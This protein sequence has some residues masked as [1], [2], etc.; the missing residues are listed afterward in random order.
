MR[1]P[2]LLAA[3]SPVLSGTWFGA[4]RTIEV[5]LRKTTISCE[6]GA[7]WLGDISELETSEHTCPAAAFPGET[8]PVL[9]DFSYQV[10]VYAFTNALTGVMRYRR[11]SMYRRSLMAFYR[12]YT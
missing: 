8:F 6:G 12:S 3:L 4:G 1:L 2:C 11:A 10:T 5:R 7:V 9:F